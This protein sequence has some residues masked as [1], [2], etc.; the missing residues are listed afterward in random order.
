MKPNGRYNRKKEYMNEQ[1]AEA[2][3]SVPVPYMRRAKEYLNT[4]IQPLSSN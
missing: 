4:R 2:E 1:L 3:L